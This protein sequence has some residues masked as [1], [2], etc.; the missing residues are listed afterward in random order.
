MTG[1]PCTT[2]EQLAQQYVDDYNAMIESIEKYKGFYVGRYELTKDENGDPTQKPGIVLNGNAD[3]N[4][5]NN[6]HRPTMDIVTDFIDLI[7]DEKSDF[8]EKISYVFDNPDDKRFYF[9]KSLVD[10]IRNYRYTKM[11]YNKKCLEGYR[12]DDSLIEDLD[13]FKRNF[14]GKIKSYKNFRELYR[15]R[16]V[17]LYEKEQE[18]ARQ[19]QEEHTPTYA[20]QYSEV[21]Q[22]DYPKQKVKTYEVP[23]QLSLFDMIDKR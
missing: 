10:D 23:G 16:K 15:F 19:E 3:G 17:Y 21:R 6:R 18:K 5:I 9:S 12:Q 2:V 7:E 13:V 8:V 14:L 4:N 1:S 22:K 20:E 11:V